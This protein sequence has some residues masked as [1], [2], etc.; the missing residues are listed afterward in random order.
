MEQVRPSSDL[1]P[2]ICS[3]LLVEL[4]SGMTV[5]ELMDEVLELIEDAGDRSR[6]LHQCLKKGGK[7]I[8]SFALPLSVFPDGASLA[9]FHASNIPVPQVAES[10][11]IYNVRFDTDLSDTVRLF[12]DDAER[13]LSL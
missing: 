12:T 11:P 7:D 9:V 1:N 8:Y 4:P 13:I 6:V 5:G 3:I 10:A 2:Y